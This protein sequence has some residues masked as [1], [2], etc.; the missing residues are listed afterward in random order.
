MMTLAPIA[1]ISSIDFFLL[2]QTNHWDK[3]EEFAKSGL[4]PFCLNEKCSRPVIVFI[5]DQWGWG[6]MDGKCLALPYTKKALHDCVQSTIENK[7]LLAWQRILI[8]S[9]YLQLYASYGDIEG[10]H[11]L[12][13]CVQRNK[14]LIAPEF[15]QEP[16]YQAILNGH[17]DVLD[18]L[19]MHSSLN[20]FS[21]KEQENFFS[22]ALSKGYLEVM[23]LLQDKGCL[24]SE[25]D[26]KNCKQLQDWFESTAETA[27]PSLTFYQPLDRSLNREH[28][29]LYGGS[30]VQAIYQQET[31]KNVVFALW[32][33]RSDRSLCSFKTLLST[34]GDRRRHIA[35]LCETKN[36][37]EFCIKRK[38]IMTTTLCGQYQRYG[39][40]VD[41]PKTQQLTIHGQSYLLTQQSKDDWVG[42]IIENVYVGF[43]DEDDP[44]FS[45]VAIIYENIVTEDW[46]NKPIELKNKIAH[47]HWLLAHISPFSRGSAAISETL[48]DAL[49]LMHGYIPQSIEKGKSLDLE[50]MF[51]EDLESFQA[52]YPIAIKPSLVK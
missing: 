5:G 18:A 10:I 1:G 2:S 17:L 14:I 31:R 29:Q 15:L 9:E 34:L 25:I 47:L 7:N 12:L 42:S 39:D 28:L 44:L 46:S 30:D 16:I 41:K 22:S 45:Y 23:Q 3:I 49:W 35:Y 26:Q 36:A 51:S 37:S 24:S 32:S 38:H 20:N 6:S 19:L 21:K 27:L 40:K 43:W 13:S 52:I 33:I 8:I 11:L 4:T 48:T 50:A